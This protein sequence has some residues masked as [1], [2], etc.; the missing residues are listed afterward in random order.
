MNHEYD[1]S[2][3]AYGPQPH[4]DDVYKPT[5]AD[6]A[7]WASTWARIQ[8]DRQGDFQATGNE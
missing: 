6:K 7:R 3:N 8:Y 1:E 5:A 2:C 4:D